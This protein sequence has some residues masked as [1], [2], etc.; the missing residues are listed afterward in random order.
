MRSRPIL[1]RNDI[2]HICERPLRGAVVRG[3]WCR[4]A[5]MTVVGFADHPGAG[6]VVDLETYPSPT[7]IPDAVSAEPIT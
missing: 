3:W 5:A 7:A 6:M 1:A 2:G 4:V